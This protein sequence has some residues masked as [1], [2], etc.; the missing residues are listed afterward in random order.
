MAKW[1]EKS[2]FLE[3]N[4]EILDAKLWV[5]LET[6]DITK[7]LANFRTLITIFSN[8]QKVLRI[9]VFPFTSQENRFLRDQIY[10]KTEKLQQTGY[11]IIF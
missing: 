2:T 3:K 6:L 9:I 1:K 11:S 7:K 8:S 5:I 4:K 10:Q